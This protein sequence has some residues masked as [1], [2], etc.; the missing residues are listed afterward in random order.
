MSL[1]GFSDYKRMYVD[2]L[3]NTLCFKL[4]ESN[5]VGLESAWKLLLEKRLGT[6]WVN[7]L[8]TWLNFAH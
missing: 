8:P 5:I 4:M 3:L 6:V 7:P 1:G 2:Q